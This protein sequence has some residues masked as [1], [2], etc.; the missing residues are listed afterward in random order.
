[1][2]LG[3]KVLTCLYSR[4]QSEKSISKTESQPIS[5]LAHGQKN[6][7]LLPHCFHTLFLPDVILCANAHWRV[8]RCI[9]EERTGTKNTKQKKCAVLAR[10]QKDFPVKHEHIFCPY[11]CR[12]IAAYGHLGAAVLCNE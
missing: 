10:V 7:L 8:Q 11:A 4:D 2:G 12:H 6:C 3:F 1:M 9:G 5:P